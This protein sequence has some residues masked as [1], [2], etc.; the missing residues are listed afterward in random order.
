MAS[1]GED[2][3]RQQER[4]RRLRDC[5]RELGPAGA[6]YVAVCDDVLRRAD[7]AAMS[8]DVAEMM[9]VYEEMRD[10]KE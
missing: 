8:G 6:F 9:R 10:I 7:R 3:P 4:V 1:L 5:G 2:F